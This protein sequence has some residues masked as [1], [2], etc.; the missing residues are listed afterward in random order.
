MPSTAYG[1]P[2]LP[3][4][5]SPPRI[6][7]STPASQ[8]KARGSRRARYRT[9]KGNEMSNDAVTILVL[10]GLVVFGVLYNT[11]VAKAEQTETGYT[12]FLVV[13]GVVVTVAA[14]APLIGWQ[15]AMVVG[16]AFAASGLPMVIGSM[17]RYVRRTQA[18]H[19]ALRAEARRAMGDDGHAS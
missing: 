16:L 6:K 4:A 13:G 15:A 5:I 7:D 10:G 11:L 12:A 17:A 18:E 1:R 9:M 3:P 14:T 8:G 2:T 19:Q